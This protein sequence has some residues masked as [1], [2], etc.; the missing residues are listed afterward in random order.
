MDHDS[1]GV[2]GSRGNFTGVK[3]AVGNTSAIQVYK[4]VVHYANGGAQE[5][6]MRNLIQAG[7][8]TSVMDLRGDERIIRTLRY[9]VFGL[10]P[11]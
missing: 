1:I 2:T 9:C 7:G 6:E 4:V 8:E 3:I 5:L 11:F 10:L